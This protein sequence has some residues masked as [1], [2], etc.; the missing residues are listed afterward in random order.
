MADSN[1]GEAQRRV[2]RAAAGAPPGEVEGRNVRPNEELIALVKKAD[3]HLEMGDDY[4]VNRKY[5]EALAE[6]KKGAAICLELLGLPSGDLTDDN[7]FIGLVFSPDTV[8]NMDRLAYQYL[9]ASSMYLELGKSAGT[10]AGEANMMSKNFD[11]T[12]E[13]FWLSAPDILK[14][15]T[16]IQ[17]L[18]TENQKLRDHA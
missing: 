16:E 3:D 7:P 8:A 15:Q 13:W 18:Q 10:T 4:E 11:L 1:D 6:Y 9:R 17:K 5:E 2:K 12:R 14:L